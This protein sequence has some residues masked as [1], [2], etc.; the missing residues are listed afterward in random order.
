MKQDALKLAKYW[1]NCLAD[2]ERNNGALN[3]EELKAFIRQPEHV[4]LAG[5][6]AEDTLAAC[7]R[8]EPES[9]ERVV[10][11]LRPYLF[12]STLEH[13][14]KRTNLPRYITP[15]VT[16]A[17]LTR[18]GKL[19]PTAK[20]QVP[21]NILE[22]L[23][24]GSFA[25]ANVKDVDEQLS[26]QR[27]L[28]D[29][30]WGEPATHQAHWAEYQRYIG[31]LLKAICPHWPSEDD[32]YQRLPE[33]LVM[34]EQA[35]KGASQHIVSLYEHIQ[36]TKPSAPLF[37]RY[38]ALDY[39][40]PES[41][42]GKEQGFAERLAHS[43]AEHPLAPAQRDALTHLLACPEGDVLAVN[44]PPGTGK[45]TLLLSVVATLWTKAA[46][47]GPDAQP[48]V[49]VASS[50][51]NQ[52]VTNIL[53]A[54]AQDFSVGN[55]P[56]AGR[57]LP[58]LGSFGA[59]LPADSKAEKAAQTYQTDQFFTA[60][61][62]SEGL[63]VAKERY[64]ENAAVAFPDS[65]ALTVEHTVDLLRERIESGAAELSALVDTWDALVQ[66][67]QALNEMLGSRSLEEA[68]NRVNEQRLADIRESVV[69]RQH[70]LE[71]YLADESIFLALFNWVP[72][73]GRK[74]I[75]RARV[76]LGDKSLPAF[77]CE[78]EMQIQAWRT[79]SDIES[80]IRHWLD[81]A[82]FAL[83]TETRRL[84]V[85]QHLVD[86]RSLCVQA[87]AHA[88][89]PLGNDFAARAE[90]LD[91]AACDAP[92]DT[93][94]R[95]PLFLLTT[96]YWEGRWLL[97]MNEN[98]KDIEAAAKR[99]GK[100]TVIPRW[101]RW[102]KL[103][104][105]IVSTFFMLPKKLSVRRND[106][107]AWKTDYLYDFADLLIVDEAGQVQ[108]EV[109]GASFALA[110]KALVIGDTEQ[111]EPIWST[112]TPVDKGN[113]FDADLLN[114]ADEDAGYARIVELGKASASGSAMRIAQ[115]ASRYHYD[116]QLARGMYLYEHRRCYDSIVDY[117]NKLCYHGRLQ[118]MRRDPTNPALPPMGYLHVPGIC[119]RGHG[120]S[121]NNVLEAETIAAWLDENRTE[122]ESRYG[123]HI[124]KIVGIVTPFGAQV[125]AIQDA[126]NA[127]GIKTG[128]EEDAVTVGTVHAL[129][130]AARRVIL[131][132][133][134][135]SKHANGGFI[136]Q[137]NSM[138]NVA[139]SRAQDSFLV[140][141]DMD[142][143]TLA[144]P[145]SPRALLARYL[146]AEPENELRFT[147]PPRQDLLTTRTGLSHLHNAEEHDQFLLAALR[148]ATREIHI[149]SPWL[150]LSRVNEI[151]AMDAMTEATS[152][153]VQISI[154]TDV[155]FNVGKPADASKSIELKQAIHTL[156]GVGVRVYPINRIHSKLVMADDNLLCVGSFNWFSASRDPDYMRH[157]TSM[158]YHGP[159]V[160]EEIRTN[161]EGLGKLVDAKRL[162]ERST[163]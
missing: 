47:A 13:G 70:A 105:C 67:R 122:L 29:P 111:I 123:Q 106:N 116:H 109:A 136:D 154:Y 22:P 35:S 8:D 37:E 91:L 71:R 150:K 83:E 23:E 46:L 40:A 77:S 43:H 69:A 163:A 159:D 88:L 10:V 68:Q 49:I 11:S 6:L 115:N 41:C 30:Q 98:L 141:G 97:E 138:L 112:N 99:T 119:K 56:F 31:Q 80:S 73:I 133:P 5:V 76:A 26:K 1:R 132:S 75:A 9:A 33:L 155:E 114:T 63:S 14:A 140:F 65:K 32:P 161:R 21:R 137:R 17:I 44:G 90:T 66:S 92:A 104:P 151:G 120:R 58:Q 39:P 50:T 64:L 129:Q 42:L 84:K 82:T 146:F 135:Y 107:G 45:T 142:L 101:R 158:V 54:F 48:P 27:P 153:H 60:L 157:E 124:S 113:L 59:Y 61:E 7:F 143:F 28:A 57:W 81:D 55:G 16:E 12:A 93:R 20:T 160:A 147:P 110:R 34:K 19:W 3:D 100:T 52:A 86:K 162:V 103:T 24:R 4:M 85:L 117:C 131:F 156:K 38:A 139:V 2:A 149:V 18:D 148:Q 51:N 15:I 36:T 95:F 126:C 96:H 152:R 128:K 25:V 74:R 134:T 108:P 118:P 145:G 94:L 144:Q 53:D 102:M 72:S 62:T 87:W 78:Q 89:E 125:G 127:K 130:G 79:F 121:R